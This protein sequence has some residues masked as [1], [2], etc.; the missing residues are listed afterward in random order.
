MYQQPLL[1]VAPSFLPDARRN[2]KYQPGLLLHSAALDQSGLECL[3]CSAT[4]PFFCCKETL[5]KASYLDV[6]SNG[7]LIAKPRV[8][9]CFGVCT[10]TSIGVFHHFDDPIVFGETAVKGEMCAPF[11]FLCVDCFSLCGEALVMRGSSC[12]GVSLFAHANQYST[13]SWLGCCACMCPISVMYG[14][15]PGEALKTA[16]VINQAVSVFRSGNW[17]KDQQLTGTVLVVPMAAPV[18]M[19]MDI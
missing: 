8:F 11:P 9:C 10:Q 12:S 4:F 13:P 1:T 5:A 3:Y 2:A 6:Y 18:V 14:L 7:V 19:H 16:G 15:A 17:P